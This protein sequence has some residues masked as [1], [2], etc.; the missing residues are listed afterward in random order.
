MNEIFGISMTS[1]MVTLVSLLAICLL[2]VAWVALRR[3]VI[4][5]MGMR[6]IPRRRAQTVLIVVGLML[7]TLIMSAALGTGDT[8]DYSMTTDVYDTYQ[9]VD[10][11]VVV[12]Q[13]TDPDL[14]V[15][16]TDMNESS[17]AT[18][19]NALA[20]NDNVDGIM[21]ELRVVVPALNE[22]SQL[23]EPVV[24]LVGLDPSRLDA[25]GGIQAAN[26]DDIDLATIPAGSVVIG[27][28]TG[29]ELKAN[30][31]DVITVF[32][33]N[34][35]K[36]LTVA[37]IAENSYLTGGGRDFMSGLES[38][39]ML[40]PL[41]QAQ[42]LTGKSGLISSVLISNAGGVR[43]SVALSDSVVDSLRPALEG[44]GLGVMA[45]KQ[46]W[47]ETGKDFGQ[48][49]TGLFLVLGLF[50]IA[51]GILLIVLIFTMLA[52]ERRAEMGMARAVG[53][54][55]GQLIQ[56]FVSEGSGYA[57]IA[58]FVGSA[59]GILAAI[60]IGFGMGFLFGDFVSITPHVTPRSLVAA[61]SLGVV[62]TFLAVVGSSWKVSRLNVVAAIRDLPDESRSRPRKRTLIWA[63]LLL[64]G[65]GLLTL[66]G[67]NSGSAFPFYAGMSMM[68]FGIAF[69][70]RFLRIPSRPIYSLIGLYLIV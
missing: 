57:L 17:V 60:G 40:M 70:L 9:L 23:A 6:N 42:E 45:S 32:V 44:T 46:E 30:V 27:K 61:Y 15:N 41:A 14:G 5:K 2:T 69:I 26:G 28:H 34:Q 50:S 65:G 7:S 22:A 3:P 31:G 56:Q 48:I 39:G 20:G 18:I 52:A 58:G 55:R 29:E 16:E 36:P 13:T 53:Q 21:P 66:S 43:D 37:A 11:Q 62:I 67:T 51:A 25:F 33:A 63:G 12:S 47:V 49:F 10:E 38:I 35:P 8:I 19:E 24:T 59:L 54:H 4:F 68:P 1:I 64:L